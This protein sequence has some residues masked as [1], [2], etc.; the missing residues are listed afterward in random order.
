MVANTRRRT[1]AYL[2]TAMA[3]GQVLLALAFAWFASASPLQP[4]DYRTKVEMPLWFAILPGVTA[5]AVSIHLWFFRHVDR[6]CPW[7]G[8]GWLILV[9]NMFSFMVFMLMIS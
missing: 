3:L 9:A 8:L 7:V 6:A 1:V 5:L 2:M 4:D